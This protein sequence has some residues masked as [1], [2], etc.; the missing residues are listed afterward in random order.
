MNFLF[1]FHTN[2]GELKSL[3]LKFKTPLL[4]LYINHLGEK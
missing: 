2:I 1:I 3:I 4:L